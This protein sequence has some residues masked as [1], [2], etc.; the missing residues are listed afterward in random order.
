V[1]NAT[2]ARTDGPIEVMIGARAVLA[3]TAVLVFADREA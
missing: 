2:N 1:V 3:W